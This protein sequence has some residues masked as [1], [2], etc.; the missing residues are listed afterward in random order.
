MSFE[1]RVVTIPA[2]ELEGLRTMALCEFEVGGHIVPSAADGACS[3]K[4][5]AKIIVGTGVEEIGGADAA[6]YSGNSQKT[7]RLLSTPFT[8]KDMTI[9]LEM[10]GKP[11]AFCNIIW[12]AHPLLI[13]ATSPPSLGDIA[14][15]CVLGNLRNWAQQGQINT[16]VIVAFEGLYE[17]NVTEPRFRELVAD[18]DRLMKGKPWRKKDLP[19]DVAAELRRRVFD[20]L[21]DGHEAYL[22]EREAL[23]QKHPAMFNIDGAP[24]HTLKKWMCMSTK[25]CGVQALDFPYKRALDTPGFRDV[26]ERFHETNAWT[27]ALRDRGFY[28]R[29]F[30]YAGSIK[31]PVKVRT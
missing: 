13:G 3:L 26:I 17:Y 27:K 12:H 16:Q 9:S 5:S 20:E 22:A 21:R 1:E 18:T 15:H 10:C 31:L 28:C 6:N 24:T 25:A 23:V 30:P 4:R 2:S 8:A 7:V 11:G 14:A 19:S 29:Y